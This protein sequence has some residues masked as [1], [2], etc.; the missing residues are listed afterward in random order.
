[1]GLGGSIVP[2]WGVSHGLGYH[3]KRSHKR[4]IGK[5]YRSLFILKPRPVQYH[6]IIGDPF[7]LGSQLLE[8]LSLNPTFDHECMFSAAKPVCNGVFLTFKVKWS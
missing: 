6:D 1:M 2:A 5:L 4:L 3:F 7:N 8:V